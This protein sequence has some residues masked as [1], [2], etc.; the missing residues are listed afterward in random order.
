MTATVEECGPLTALAVRFL[1]EYQGGAAHPPAPETYRDALPPGAS[2]KPG[3]IEWFPAFEERGHLAGFVRI[4]MPNDVTTYSVSET[5]TDVG[6]VFFLQKTAGKGTDRRRESYAVRCVNGA[7]V[8]CECQSRVC[9]K[10]KS[11]CERLI[12]NGWV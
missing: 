11:A 1:H 2:G 3:A 7:A 5:P 6:R 4:E 10:H 12:A 8:S 9:C